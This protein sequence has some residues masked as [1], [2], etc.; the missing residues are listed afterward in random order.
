MKENKKS[1][2]LAEQQNTQVSSTRN[3][4]IIPDTRDYMQEEI[5]NKT[6]PPPDMIEELNSK[7]YLMEFMK[8]AVTWDKETIIQATKLL[9]EIQKKR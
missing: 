2:L 7:P 1:V 8:K 5:S 6:A 9:K 3:N 4:K